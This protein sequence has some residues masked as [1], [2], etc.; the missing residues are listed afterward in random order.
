[1]KREVCGQDKV[2]EEVVDAIVNSEVSENEA[3]TLRS[4][5]YITAYIGDDNATALLI[6]YISEEEQKSAGVKR[7]ER[8]KENM[9]NLFTNKLK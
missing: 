4:W 3:K 5:H 8:L 6:E 9:L 1:M 2:I 7:I